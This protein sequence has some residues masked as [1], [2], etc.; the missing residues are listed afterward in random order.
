[1]W[2]SRQVLEQMIICTHLFCSPWKG[3]CVL[4]APG[5]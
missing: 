4:Q 2:M 5:L 1:M 3:A